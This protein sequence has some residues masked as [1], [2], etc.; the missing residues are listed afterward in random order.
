MNNNN[1]I[2]K[3]HYGSPKVSAYFTQKYAKDDLEVRLINNHIKPNNTILALGCGSGR[4]VQYLLSKG[5]QVLANDL[6][7]AMVKLSKQM[8]PQVPHITGDASELQLKEKFDCIIGLFCLVN[9]M[10][11]ESTE[12]LIDNAKT[13][14]LPGGKIILS[15]DMVSWNL[16]EVIKML[17]TPIICLRLGRKYNLFDSF[18][19]KHL[20]VKR[21]FVVHPFTHSNLKHLFK[22]FDY[23]LDKDQRKN[24]TEYVLVAKLKKE[25]T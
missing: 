16:R 22:D 13:M 3:E 1:R 17:I 8:N 6:S 12:R 2:I 4:E 24:G 9:Y 10:G 19:R 11:L 21:T 14:L 23:T 5:C 20:E 25:E 15:F 18:C 7:P